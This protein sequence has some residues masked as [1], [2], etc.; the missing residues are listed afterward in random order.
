MGSATDI[1]HH[2]H[3]PFYLRVIKK[4]LALCPQAAFQEITEELRIMRLSFHPSPRPSGGPILENMDIS[5][6]APSDDARNNEF[7][8]QREVVVWTPITRA[9][10]CADSQVSSLVACFSNTI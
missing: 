4:L 10:S 9:R 8:L 6:A 3:D 7:I 2:L 5:D 1:A